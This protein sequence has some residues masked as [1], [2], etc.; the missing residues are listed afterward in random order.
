[1]LVYERER[2]LASE[3]KNDLESVLEK[4]IRMLEDIDYEGATE[5]PLSLLEEQLVE[6]TATLDRAEKIQSYMEEL[7]EINNTKEEIEA[8]NNSLPK[9]F[10]R[11]AEDR[12]EGIA[13]IVK[14]LQGMNVVDA[15]SI[16]MNRIVKE[17]VEAFCELYGVDYGCDGHGN[18]SWIYFS[19][20]GKKLD[21]EELR[22]LG[23]PNFR[24]N[25]KKEEV[26]EEVKEE[27]SS[28]PS[29]GYGFLTPSGDFI[30]SP[31]GTHEKSALEIIE[32]NGWEEEYRTWEFNGE[33]SLARDFLIYAK[34]YCL[35]H[36]PSAFGV[37]QVHVPSKGLTKKQK[38]FLYDYFI[39]EGNPDRGEY[40]LSLNDD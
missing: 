19:K 40:Y 2:N 38:E 34:G 35:I 22:A 36:N 4:M 7:V 10:S 27:V 23:V 11:L 33:Y 31:W 21:L 1:M 6:L 25:E 9:K 24:E 12:K 16:S 18:W 29:L 28:E 3:I 20:D 8:D 5:E 14:V 15:T 32:K 37:T 13:K 17:D 39:K 30:E 26:V